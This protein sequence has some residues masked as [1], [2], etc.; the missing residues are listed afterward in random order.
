MP[1]IERG[2]T[3]SQLRLDLSLWLGDMTN[4]GIFNWSDYVETTEAV[5]E[6]GRFRAQRGQGAYL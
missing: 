2:V 1:N 5:T 6:A 4:A 3:A